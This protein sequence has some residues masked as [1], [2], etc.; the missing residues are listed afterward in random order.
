MTVH[1]TALASR[2]NKNRKQPYRVTFGGLHSIQVV[3]TGKELQQFV[4]VNR[5]IIEEM[6]R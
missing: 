5:E 6:N 1:I 4:D 3:M 2:P